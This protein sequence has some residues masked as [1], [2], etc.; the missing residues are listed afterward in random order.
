MLLASQLDLRCTNATTPKVHGINING[1]GNWG[2]TFIQY[3]S[4]T[5]NAPADNFGRPPKPVRIEGNP[6]L[7]SYNLDE[8]DKS[9]DEVS[10]SDLKILGS[11]D[12]GA[13]ID[14]C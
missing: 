10:L 3:G 11:C 7:H 14:C 2:N 8:I 12:N 5:I 1:N 9:L 6:F 4:S 13:S